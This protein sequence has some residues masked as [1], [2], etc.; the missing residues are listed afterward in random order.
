[1]KKLLLVMLLVGCGARDV[2]PPTGSECSRDGNI[3]ETCWTCASEPVCAWWGSEN[4]D[5]RGCH[6]R[7]DAMP[8]ED[9]VVVRLSDACNELPLAAA[10]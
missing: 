10:R 6:A 7:T 9:V 2:V 5:H 3:A 1:M 8:H 4:P